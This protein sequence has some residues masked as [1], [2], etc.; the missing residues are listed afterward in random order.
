MNKN[1][2][3]LQEHLV[4]SLVIVV[5]ILAGAFFGYKKMNSHNNAVIPSSTPIPSASKVSS[6]DTSKTPTSPKNTQTQSSGPQNTSGPGPQLPT[7]D[8]VSNHHP[9][10]TVAEVSVCNTTPGA[11]CYIEF[12]N[13]S[14]VKKLEE[15]QTDGKGAVYWYWSIGSAG[16]SSGSWTVTAVAVLNGQTA[17]VADPM[18]LVIK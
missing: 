10:G 2:R 8:F 4:L 9:D 3:F 7:G 6:T 15:Q 18:T 12:T 13:G 11:S 17:K 1:I 5:I 16:L 14:T